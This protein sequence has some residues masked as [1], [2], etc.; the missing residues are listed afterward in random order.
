MWCACGAPLALAAVLL[1]ACHGGATSTPEATTLVTQAQRDAALD[2]V[3]A[4]DVAGWIDA[5]HHGLGQR[6]QHRAV[7]GDHG[8]VHRG[9]RVA[10]QRA[11]HCA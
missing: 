3:I 7:A 4:A 6:L 9:G 2:G 10:A 1:A 5:Q 11:G 8:E